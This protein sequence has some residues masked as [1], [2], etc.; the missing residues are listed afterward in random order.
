MSVH[1]GK[2]E[3]AQKEL[4]K[5][6]EEARVAAESALSEKMNKAEKNKDE[7]LEGIIK[8]IKEHQACISNVRDN[9][10]EKLKPYVAELET[11]INKKMEEAE[12]RRVEAQAKVVEIAKKET[13]DKIIS[14][15]CV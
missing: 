9:Q 8:K 3:K 10:E 1:M 2:I 12:K 13:T 7:H 14:A 5:Q 11:N 15:R 4:E 6:M